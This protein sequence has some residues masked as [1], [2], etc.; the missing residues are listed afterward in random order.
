MT[1]RVLIVCTANVCRSPMAEGLLRRHCQQRGVAATITSAGTHMPPLAVDPL[2]V[3]AVGELGIDI[4]GHRPR[5]L[6]RTLIDTDGADLLLAMTREQ[7]RHAAASAQ[8]TFRRTFTLREFVRRLALDPPAPG[9]SLTEWLDDV[10]TRRRAHDLMGNDPADDVAD[11]YGMPL[12]EHRVCAQQLDRAT[13][14]AA[15]AFANFRLGR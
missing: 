4:A 5:Q 10:A 9:A 14:D 1:L 2:A 8:G 3:T 13:A 6:T 7:L 11:P 12:H 15:A